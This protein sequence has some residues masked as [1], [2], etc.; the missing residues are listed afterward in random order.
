MTVDNRWKMFDQWA[1]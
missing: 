1:W